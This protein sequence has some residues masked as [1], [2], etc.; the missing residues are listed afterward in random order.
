LHHKRSRKFGLTWTATIVGVVI[1]FLVRPLAG[2]IGL[3][4]TDQPRGERAV[5]AFFGIRG[6]GSFY[7]L[8]YAL[9]EAEFAEADL[10]WALTG[11]VVLVSIFVHGTTVTPVMRRLDKQ[12]QVERRVS[13]RR[14]ARIKT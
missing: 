4:G 1:L 9:N 8:A 13:A 11:F 5:I 6:I 12:W 14:Q 10:L 7:Y 2:L 3:V